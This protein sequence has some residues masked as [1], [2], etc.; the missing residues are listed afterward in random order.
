MKRLTEIII[1]ATFTGSQVC[2]TQMPSSVE[3]EPNDLHLL[4]Q[5][6]YPTQD[7]IELEEL[8]LIPPDVIVSK[9]ALENFRFP[10]QTRMQMNQSYQLLDEQY[11]T[12]Y[13]K[14]NNIA[15]FEDL[16]LQAVAEWNKLEES[17]IRF[18]FDNNADLA[19]DI[20]GGNNGDMFDPV[21]IEK[22]AYRGQY[23]QYV[24]LNYDKVLPLLSDPEQ[25]KYLMM[26][27]L[28]HLVGFAHAVTD[29]FAGS[30][31]GV[32]PGTDFTDSESIM[33]TPDDILYNKKKWTGFS[34][35]DI[36]AIETVYPRKRPV[37]DLVRVPAGDDR[38]DVRTKYRFEATCDRPSAKFDIKIERKEAPGKVTIE[39]VDNG[40]FNA[41]FHMPGV[42]RI[43][44]NVKNIAKPFEFVRNYT[45]YSPDPIIT[46]PAKIILGE[47]C[48]IGRA[49]V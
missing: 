12:I 19:V 29:P 26:H 6:G 16:L 17:S 47:T 40:I 39:P 11:H 43:I 14:N 13:L 18:V 42:Y 20:S 4:Q 3:E 7:V 32:I 22:P 31:E 21:S 45:V 9:A 30:I 23:S 37:Y 49:H 33:R 48:K 46:P 34:K 15:R 36:R 5:L 25:G 27:I 1:M 41:T 10:P 28:G 38:L 24:R 8:Y 2:C 35:S 44:V